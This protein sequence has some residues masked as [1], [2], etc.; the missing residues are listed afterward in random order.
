MSDPLVGGDTGPYGELVNCNLPPDLVL[1]FIPSLVALLIRAEELKGEPLTE[2]EVVAIRDGAQVIVNHAD[3]V[4][5]VEEQL[6][7]VDVNP[8][9]VWESWLS[10]QAQQGK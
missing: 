2:K 4:A 8:A 6:G 3:V 9:N 1:M 7:Y 10:I 5:A